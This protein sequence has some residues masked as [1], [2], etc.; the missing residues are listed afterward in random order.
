[1]YL[2]LLVAIL[3][4]GSVGL[5]YG[6]DAVQVPSKNLH[7]TWIEP[8]T[9]ADGTILNDLAKVVLRGTVDGVPLADAEA[10]VSGLTGGQ[11]GFYTYLN[12]CQPNTN[13]EVVLNVYAVDLAGNESEAAILPKTIDCLPPGKVQ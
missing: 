6:L 5:A 3:I 1:M 13:P 10:A 7:V 8:S 11:E 2:Y 12:I 4:G 9:N